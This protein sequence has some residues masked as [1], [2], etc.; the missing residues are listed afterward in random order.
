MNSGRKGKGPRHPEFTGM[1]GGSAQRGSVGRPR[2][3]H[4]TGVWLA[5]T[6]PQKGKGADAQAG[7]AG[8][9]PGTGVRPGSWTLPSTAGERNSR[10]AKAALPVPPDRQSLPKRHKKEQ[11]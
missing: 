1:P 4:W 9:C 8:E 6:A 3:P 5:N 2:R 10:G 11:V 7:R